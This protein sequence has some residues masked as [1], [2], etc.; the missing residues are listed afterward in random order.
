MAFLLGRDLKF[1]CKLET[2]NTPA[3]N[4]GTPSQPRY[5]ADS[6]AARVVSS[7]MEF[8]VARENRNDARATRSALGRITG[9]QEVSWSVESYMCPK[10]GAVPNIAPMLECAMGSVATTTYSLAT[11]LNTFQMARLSEDVMREEVFGCWVDEMTVSASGGDP[12]TIS[13]S[14]GACE[15]ALT[16]TATTDAT[17]SGKGL[18]VASGGTNF[19]PGSLIA[20][21]DVTATDGTV[22]A[23]STSATDV[24]LATSRSYATS[25]AVTPHTPDG[26]Y[27]THG[28]PITGISGTLSLDSETTLNVTSFDVTVS[29]GV[30]PLSD[31]FAKKGTSDFIEGFRDVTGTVTVRATSDALTKFQK[32]YQL[33]RPALGNPTTD[34]VGPAPTFQTLA[35][36]I[37]LGNVSGAKQIIT[38]PAIELGFAGIEIPEAEEATIAIPFTALATASNNEM[39]FEWNAS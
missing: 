23:G 25:K 19:M 12:V 27:T 22:V 30:K 39:T 9:K 6:N 37:T 38:L 3:A 21:A 5:V 31:E 20:I 36:T 1:Y 28:D 10:S 11:E 4:Y 35:L 8:T 17:S 24:R 18:T 26:T 15:Y 32:R 13:F 14:G 16:G 29:N 34:T 7:S 2:I 33:A